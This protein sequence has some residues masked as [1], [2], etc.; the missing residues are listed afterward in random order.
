MSPGGRARFPLKPTEEPIF[1]SLESMPSFLVKSVTLAKEKRHSHVQRK[2]AWAVMSWIIS[3]PPQLQ[4]TTLLVDLA[5]DVKPA[6]IQLGG[7]QP[8]VLKTTTSVL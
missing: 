6:T 1:R 2:V 8:V 5:P 7:R 3:A 4:L